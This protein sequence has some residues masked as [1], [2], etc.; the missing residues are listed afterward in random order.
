MLTS[1]MPLS[2]I[3]QLSDWDGLISNSGLSVLVYMYGGWRQKL[4][5]E[6]IPTTSKPISAL[7]QSMGPHPQ[8]LVVFPCIPFSTEGIR[9]DTHVARADTVTT[10]SVAGSQCRRRLLRGSSSTKCSGQKFSYSRLSVDSFVVLARREA[11]K[12][13]TLVDDLQT[14]SGSPANFQWI[15][16]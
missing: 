3:G 7:A 10:I 14:I 8:N 6:E 2:C 1:L 12:Q 5:S 16:C 9:C 4:R 11:M 15:T 13:L